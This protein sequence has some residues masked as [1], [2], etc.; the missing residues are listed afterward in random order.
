MKKIRTHLKRWN[1]WRKYNCNSKLYKIFVLFGWYSP[2]FDSM[3]SCEGMVEA[4][5]R[6]LNWGP[7]HKVT[8]TVKDTEPDD[9]L[10]IYPPNVRPL[11]WLSIIEMAVIA[12]TAYC[13]SR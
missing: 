6:G 4:F 11:F 2:S 10:R 9:D 7:E 3:V 5:K 8:L 12:I 13:L 1:R